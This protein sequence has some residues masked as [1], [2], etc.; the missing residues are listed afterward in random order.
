MQPMTITPSGPQPDQAAPT[1]M[2]ARMVLQ[3]FQHA[4]ANNI[5]QRLT[6]E[7]AAGLVATLEE[8]LKGAVLVPTPPPTP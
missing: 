7:L 5:N 3:R 6:V 8:A 1:D 4:L 2:L